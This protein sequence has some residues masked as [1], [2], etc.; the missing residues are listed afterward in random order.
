MPTAINSLLLLMMITIMKLLKGPN[1]EFGP[2][3]DLLT[4][5]DLSPREHLS[6]QTAF[7][8]S[9]RNGFDVRLRQSCQRV[10]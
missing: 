9:Y 2:S 6:C 7:K 1:S 4:V 10:H 3:V 5:A 8:K